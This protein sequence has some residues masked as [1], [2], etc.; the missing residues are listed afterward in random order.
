[1]FSTLQH[2]T[3]FLHLFSCC[4]NSLRPNLLVGCCLTLLTVQHSRHRRE[5]SLAVLLQAPHDL[6]VLISQ[7]PPQKKKALTNSLH[8]HY[9][10]SDSFFLAFIFLILIFFFFLIF[11]KLICPRLFEKT[12]YIES[13]SNLR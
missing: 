11:P 10:V 6:S 8:H 13:H 5:H 1:M 7:T 9:N 3:P 4:P 2:F 12:Q